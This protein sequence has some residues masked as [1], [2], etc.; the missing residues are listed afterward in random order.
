MDASGRTTTKRRRRRRPEGVNRARRG[1]HADHDRAHKF[2]GAWPRRRNTLGTYRIEWTIE[3]ARRNIITRPVAF[4]R[5]RIRAAVA[6]NRLRSQ[7]APA[8]KGGDGTATPRARKTPNCP[9]IGSFPAG[10]I[11]GWPPAA[12]RPSPLYNRSHAPR[13]VV[14]TSTLYRRLRETIATKTPYRRLA[15]SSAFTCPPSPF[16][17]GDRL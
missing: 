15:L 9:L 12:C 3:S 6:Q 16:A 5:P 13:P 2:A 11:E 7:R 14:A 4:Q 17:P 8:A 10:G 1:A